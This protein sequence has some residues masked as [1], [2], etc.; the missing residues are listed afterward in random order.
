MADEVNSPPRA[1]REPAELFR[2]PDAAAYVRARYKMP[3]STAWLAKLAVIGGGSPFHKAGRFPLYTKPTLDEWA[4]ARLGP[5]VSS[6]SEA[7]AA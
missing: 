1:A 2:R 7:T 6:T 3:C 4:H 5:L